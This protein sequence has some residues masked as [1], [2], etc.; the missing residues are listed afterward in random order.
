[1]VSA[2]EIKTTS[3]TR[4]VRPL[5]FDFWT[6]KNELQLVYVFPVKKISK[7]SIKVNKLVFSQTASVF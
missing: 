3:R 4:K 6:L 7:K 1:M 5:V 2:S